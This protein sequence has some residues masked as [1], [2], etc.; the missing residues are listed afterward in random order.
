MKD[1]CTFRDNR[2]RGFLSLVAEKGKLAEV[3][4][5]HLWGGDVAAAEAALRTLTRA[6]KTAGNF[7]EENLA[8]SISAYR[9]QILR[10]KSQKNNLR[11]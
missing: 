2:D 4:D 1:F 9:R 7:N 5:L 8:Q 11:L 6:E 3:F 10:E